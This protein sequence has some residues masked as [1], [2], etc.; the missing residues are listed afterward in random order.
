MQKQKSIKKNYIFNTLYQV[1]ALIV[2]LITA[3]YIARVLGPAGV[4]KYSYTYSI[5]SIFGVFAL[6]G[7][8][9]YGQQVIAQCRDDLYQRSKNFF[10]IEIICAVTTLITIA[11]WFIFI[12]RRGDDQVYYLI[13]TFVLISIGLD[14]SWFFA[15]LEDFSLIVLRSFVIKFLTVIAI[16]TFVRSRDDLYI[17]FII[18]SVGQAIGNL[19]MWIPL[20]SRVV[21]VSFKDFY[22]RDHFKQTIVYFIPT[23]AASVY[24]LIDKTMIGMITH[25]S[26]ENGFYDQAQKIITVAYTVVA[27]LNTVMASRIAY[28]FA[29]GG[30]EEIKRR[31]SKSSD[32]IAALSYPI[33]F[34]IA[35][36][37]NTFVPWFLGPGYEVDILLLRIASP[38]VV[39]LSVHNFMAAQYLVPSGQ[40]A[41]STWGVIAGAAVNFCFNCLLIPRFGAAGALVA[42]LF[43]ELTICLVYFRMSRNFIPIT[44]F[45]KSSVKPFICAVI[46]FLFLFIS[47]RNLTS[48]TIVIL[49]Q[50]MAGM[51]IYFCAMLVFRSEIV[52][53]VVGIV[54]N[55]LK[56]KSTG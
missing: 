55:K 7:T 5:V 12:F 39:L 27:S 53:E 47:G 11:C 48:G 20:R 16:F 25:S 17:Y 35:A 51:I 40:R 49:C 1:F 23:V 18:Q 45:L 52:L 22:F 9:V 36:V 32:F 13:L 28:L 3:P 15:G 2:P 44:M 14:I 43:S 19:S 50:V 21:K 8:S 46:M 37:A 6:L 42:T 34:G 54:I 31:F 26:E 56:R 41:R 4:G 30:D 10:E 24:S 29:I 33:A 38:L